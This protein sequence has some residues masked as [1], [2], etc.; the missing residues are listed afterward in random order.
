MGKGS[1]RGDPFPEYQHSLLVTRGAE[2]TSLAGEGKE[3]LMVTAFARDPEPSPRVVNR[4][5]RAVLLER[6]LHRIH[7]LLKAQQG[8]YFF[9]VNP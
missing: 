7:Y 9:A 8:L 5:V 4:G 6:L 3:H 2:V 1:R